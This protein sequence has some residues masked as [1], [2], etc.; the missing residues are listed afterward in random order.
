MTYDA[1]FRGRNKFRGKSQ[2]R[3]RSSSS[4]RN[5][6]YCRKSHNKGNCPTFG[7]KVERKTTLKLCVEVRNV[8]L[9]LVESKPKKAKGK[10]F[11]RSVSKDMKLWMI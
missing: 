3:G 5:C 4:I 7:K 10:S 2:G 11:M 6:K 8:M 9:A 1:V